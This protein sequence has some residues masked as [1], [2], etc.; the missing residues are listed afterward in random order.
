[1]VVR[2]VNGEKYRFT[3]GQMATEMTNYGLEHALLEQ[4]SHKGF[5]RALNLTDERDYQVAQKL[6]CEFQSVLEDVDR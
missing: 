2:L 4:I 6:L 1:M 5:R 3:E